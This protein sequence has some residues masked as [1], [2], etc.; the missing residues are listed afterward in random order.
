[1]NIN[2]QRWVDRYLGIPVL[3]GLS[4]VDRLWPRRSVHTPRAVLILLLSEMG[5][6]VCAQPMI[7]RLKER[8]PDARLHVLLLKKNRGVVELLDLFE[9][10]AI[11]TIDDRS[12]LSFVR[13]SWEAIRTFRRAG[14]DIAIDCELFARV[15]AIFSWLSGAALRVGFDRQKQEGLYRG[16]VV[17][18]PVPY[19][20]YLHISAQ[21]LALAHSIESPTVPLSK[22]AAVPARPVVRQLAWPPDAIAEAGRR[23]HHDFPSL[24]G[25]RL[26][27]LYPGSGILPIRGWPIDRFEQCARAL[28]AQGYAVA[29]I[30]LPEDR[31]LAERI[32]ASSGS[33]ACV[34][35]AGYTRSLRD[36]VQLFHHADLLISNDGGPGHFAALT[37]LP[38]VSLFGPETPE[39]YAP[40]CERGVSLHR[41]LPCSPCL[42][43]YNHRNTACDGDNLC[44]KSI[45]VSDVLQAAHGLLASDA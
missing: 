35:L 16:S 33:P 44:L 21:F 1:L 38:V 4:V 3:A 13:S 12:L 25:R 23:L 17:N 5:S 19:N 45:E 26:V 41:R 14:V 31:P 30:G 24:V 37:P 36:L 39:L 15:S 6:M 11:V 42:T 10:E 22:S 34:S 9:S 8:Y 7:L 27:M 32:V 29:V 28:L 20:P 40:L 2:T 18:R 43:A